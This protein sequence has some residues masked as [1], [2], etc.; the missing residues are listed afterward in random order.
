MRSWGAETIQ[1]RFWYDEAEGGN[2]VNNLA[3]CPFVIVGAS[4][5]LTYRLLMPAIFRLRELGQWN[6]PVIGYSPDKWD[7]NQ[8]R[9]H[10]GE[11]LRQ[12]VPEFTAQRWSDFSALLHFHQGELTR[13]DFSTLQR[14]VGDGSAVIYLALPPALF[15]TA[16]QALAE[17]GLNRA[18]DG[19]R[20]L[21]VE[22]PFGH[23]LAS[24]QTLRQALHEGWQ[25]DQI[26][27]ID[28]FLGKE[29]AQ[30][31]LV[32]RLTNRFLA[33][34]WDAEHIRSVQIT[35]AETLG[36]EGRW[37]YYEHAGALRDMLQNH[38][39]QLFTLVAMDPPG[40]WSADSLHNHK[41]EV[42]RAVRPFKDVDHNAV[43]GQYVGGTVAGKPVAGYREEPHI[44]PGSTTETFAAL[45]LTV[46]NW[47]WQ[48]TP[49]YLRSGK[50]L[51][52][53]YA[54][55]AIELKEVPRGLFG[56]GHK[57]WLVFRMKPDETI[58]MVVWAKEPGLALK[59]R[60]RIL[61]TPY[62][63][64]H[65]M[66]YSAYEQLLLAVLQGDRT[67]FPRYDEVEEAWRIV[68]PVLKA[69]SQGD[70][71]T[72]P[73]GSQGPHGQTHLMALHG[74]WRRLGETDQ[75]S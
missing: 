2:I 29:T 9:E 42:L 34:M 12:F 13:S 30:N 72:Y 57:N 11:G 40:T 74:G 14:T 24:A 39:M 26:Y 75:D 32:F 5:D 4:G 56:E 71:E 45:K 20:R 66:E 37:R 54:E 21:V 50:R 10:V 59:T 61:S 70:P 1:A 43:R 47:R 53:D 60:R 31:L 35:Y 23:D 19:F 62:R 58:D 64:E 15:G 67:P 73:A 48:G 63:R 44:D 65:E 25:E 27:R 41:T 51:A 8:F 18:P 28:H 68:D 16:A 36:L 33:S 49:F 38:L 52:E 17:A 69:W 22:K 46:D 6:S 3:N 55:V 7:D